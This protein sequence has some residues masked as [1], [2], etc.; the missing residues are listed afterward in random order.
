MNIGFDLDKVFV[1]YPPFIPNWVIDKLY[2]EKD[3]GVLLYRIPGLVEQKFR[4]F[5]HQ[6]I[7]RQPIKKNLSFLQS[8]TQE[9]K[10]NLYLIS[11]RFGFLKKQTERLTKRHNFDSIFDKLYFNYLN[12]Q[13]HE[14]KDRVV[15]EVKIDRFIDDDLSLITYLAKNNPNIIFYWLNNTQ[16]KRITHN[17]FAVKSIEAVIK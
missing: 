16:E 5:S 9:K 17:I 15:K 6:S 2:K 3:N 14:F 13:P 10:H 11:S 8:L 1:D 4:Q 7:L 12:E